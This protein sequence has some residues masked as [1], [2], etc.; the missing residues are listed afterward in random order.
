MNRGFVVLLGVA[1]L[2]ELVAAVF[3]DQPRGGAMRVYRIVHLVEML[4]LIVMVLSSRPAVSRSFKLIVAG[5]LLSF[6]GD[7]INSFLFDLEHLLKPQTLLSIPPFMLAHLCYI[8]AFAGLLWSGSGLRPPV[9]RR[10]QAVAL[11]LWP[12]LA[13]GVWSVV[14]DSSAPPLMIKLSVAYSFVVTLMG[15]TAVLLALHLGQR[16]LIPAIGGCLFLFSDSVIGVF[17]LDGPD[18]P[19]WSSQL[20]FISYFMAQVMIAQTPRLESASASR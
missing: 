8:A 4:A 9:S 16:A 14:I 17:L 13:L 10:R 7:L 1:M 12:V 5:L 6:V 18:R 19:V 20:I 3:V 11:A 2:L 15:V